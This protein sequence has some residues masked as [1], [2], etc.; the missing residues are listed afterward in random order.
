MPVV[1]HLSASS[2]GLY[3]RCGVAWAYRYVDGLKIPPSGAMIRGS[4]LDEAT[5][6]HYRGK[7]K[8]VGLERDT[9]IDCAVDKHDALAPD[10]EMDMERGKSRD[11]VALASA[12]YYDGI[13]TKLR[14]RS[15]QD[16]Q[17]YVEGEVDGAKV[18][19]Y[20]DLIT[21]TSQVIDQKLKARLPSQRDLEV[22]LQLST[23]AWLTS[24]HSLALAVAQ[25]NGKASL[26]FTER[27]EADVE[28]VQ[29]LYS[30]VWCSIQAG[31]AVPA[32]PGH[33]MCSPAWCGFHSRCPFGAGG[34]SR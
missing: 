3:L 2:V 1:E 29:A 30:R 12:G 28:R 27:N 23:Y 32:E 15:Y 6:M 8:G 18:I 24:L 31:I 20:V 16:V 14:P 34:R 5:T 22:D 9:F 33:W 13:G 21:D 4:A 26:L 7:S 17:R 11:I 25:P 19:G 10:A